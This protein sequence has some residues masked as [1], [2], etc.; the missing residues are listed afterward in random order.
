MPT[1]LTRTALTDRHR[2]LGAD[3]VDFAGWEMPLA[4]TGTLAEHQQVRDAVGVFDVS[5]LGTVLLSGPGALDTISASFTND[6]TTLDDGRSQYTLC[7]DD[8][9]GIVDDLIVYRLTHDRWMVVPNAANTE[10]VVATLTENAETSGTVV[11][12][13]SRDHAILAVQG[14]ASFATVATAIGIDPGEIAYL[15]LREVE[16]FGETAIACRTGYTGEPGCELVIP[17]AAAPQVFDALLAADAAPVG[18][19]AR[20]TLRLEMGYPLHGND[21]DRTTDPYEARL[22]W[23]VKLDHG[24]FRGREALRAAKEAGPRRRLWGLAGTTRRPPRAGMTVH[25]D[26]R[27]TGVVTS[28]SYSPG[29]GT[30]IGLAYLDD[31]LGPG[32]RV[33]VDVRGTDVDFE[34]VRPPFVA[35]DPSA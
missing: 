14:P 5:H 27:E 17:N 18:L 23:A 35:A 33:T 13:G 31:P 6:P 24:D 22:G 26:G 2:E 30:G 4:Y 19:G 16:L 12:D 1:A 11:E 34:V 29:R 9:G 15:G 25:H 10:A 8:R 7:C 21:I 32:D 20:D 3:L 28:G